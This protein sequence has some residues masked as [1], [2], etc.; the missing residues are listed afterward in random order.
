MIIG[1]QEDFADVRTAQSLFAS[2]P[3]ASPPRLAAFADSPLFFIRVPYDLWLSASSNFSVSRPSLS[4]ERRLTVLFLSPRS[5]SSRTTSSAMTN[6]QGITS[7]PASRTVA[8]LAG[9]AGLPVPTTTALQGATPRGP[10]RRLRQRRPVLRRRRSQLPP[11]PLRRVPLPPTALARLAS[12]LLAVSTL[13]S[14]PRA[15]LSSQGAF[16]TSTFVTFTP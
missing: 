13:P 4:L 10:P 8:T 3:P 9:G 11:L 2:R 14:S 6:P 16:R 5:Q 12:P 1:F 15:P 7:L